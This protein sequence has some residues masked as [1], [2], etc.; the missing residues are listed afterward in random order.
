MA[1]TNKGLNQPAIGSAGWGPQLNENAS[2][3]D[4]ALGGS[5][6][7]S[8]TGVS[9]TPVPLTIEQYRNLIIKFSGVLT[10]NVTYQIPAGVGG[11]WVIENT[12]TGAFTLTVSSLGGGTSVALVP[13]F[14]TIVSDGTNVATSSA[15][16]LN[17]SVTYAKLQN[18]STGYVVIGRNAATP[19]VYGEVPFSILGAAGANGDR[20]F[21]ENGQTVTA[22]YTITNGT[23]AMSAGP[24]SINSG[25]TVTVGDGE[26]WTIV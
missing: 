25:V 8:V 23:N 5:T 4:T 16:L 18:A 19:G 13:N 20:I 3:L 2:Y 6:S 14:S 7:I 10:A 26:V 24:I 11:Q 12:T 9:S 17:G 15:A 21:W 22:S 1:T